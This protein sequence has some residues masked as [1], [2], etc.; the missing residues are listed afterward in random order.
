RT[1][2]RWEVPAGRSKPPLMVPEKTGPVLALAP[3]ADGVVVLSRSLKLQRLAPGRRPGPARSLPYDPDLV[4]GGVR[5]LLTSR[6]CA[7]VARTGLAMLAVSWP[8]GATQMVLLM[9]RKSE[10]SGKSPLPL[11]LAC[12]PSGHLVAVGNFAGE[13]RLYELATGQPLA[14]LPCG[15]EL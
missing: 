14:S 11:S 2:L 4:I 12:S 15:K 8:P 1:I 5:G 7:A 3:T 9:P 13:V 6:G 10:L